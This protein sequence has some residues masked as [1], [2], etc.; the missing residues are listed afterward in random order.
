M[1]K[2]GRSPNERFGASGGAVSSDTE[3]VTSSFAL[4]RALPI[5]P[6][7][8]KPQG[9]VRQRRERCRKGARL[10]KCVLSDNEVETERD[11]D[12]EFSPTMKRK[13]KQTQKLTTTRQ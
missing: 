9:V 6:P 13:R 3:Q 5:P 1:T 7:A 2:N 4:V 8:A 12:C 10:E 11:L